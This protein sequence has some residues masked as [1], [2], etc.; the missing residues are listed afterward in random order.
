MLSD[1][2]RQFGQSLHNGRALRRALDRS[3]PKI[4]RPDDPTSDEDDAPPLRQYDDAQE[5][6]ERGAILVAAVFEAFVAIYQR[7]T[8]DLMRLASG[9]TGV[10]RPGAIPTDLVDRLANTAAD[11]AQRVLTI[12]MRALDYMAPID[13]TFGDYLRA[14]VTS[15]ADLAPDHGVGYRVAFAEA[16]NAR[17]IYP[18][19]IFSVGPDAL[20]WQP[21]D[22]SV[23]RSGLG[24]FVRA[25]DL[26]TYSQSN[27]RLAF[28]AAKANAAGLHNWLAANLDAATAASIGLDFS[29]VKDGR[30]LFEVH[31]VRP[32]RR[33]TAEGESRNDVVAILTQW[34]NLPLDPRESIRRHVPVPRRYHVAAEPRVRQRSGSLRHLPSGQQQAET[35]TNAPVPTGA[36]RLQQPVCDGD[37]RPHGRA[38]RHAASRFVRGRHGTQGS[39]G[40]ATRGESAGPSQA[41]WTCGGATRRYW[42]P[43]TGSHVPAGSRRLFFDLVA[44]AAEAGFPSH[45]RLRGDPRHQGC[46]RQTSGGHRG[47]HQDDR[48]QG[49]CSGGDPRALRPCRRLC[50]RRRSVRRSRRSGRSEEACGGRSLVRLDRG[51]EGPAGAEAAQEPRRQDCG[52]FRHGAAD[53]RCRRHR[54]TARGGGARCGSSASAAMARRLATPHRR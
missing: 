41:E 17:G 36:R 32:A 46:R 24:D 19:D 14:V 50:S 48:R 2:A 6:H 38:V 30:P 47:H 23:Q 33:I 53:E 31:S 1:L 12:C 49:G 51:P 26:E 22:G 7:R 29:V 8:D 42:S 45:D 35:G 27:R 25:L 54:Q 34:R 4:K 37:A 39:S 40:K 13:P 18:P 10:L 44:A 28:Q 9:G 52:T 15:D 11:T 21:P 16:F 3:D 20:C 43:N 5:P